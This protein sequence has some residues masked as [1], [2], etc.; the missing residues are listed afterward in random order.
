MCGVSY[1]MH[2]FDIFIDRIRN[3]Y[4]K[5]SVGERPLIIILRCVEFRLKYG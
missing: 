2:K 3:G 4:K 5:E 1:E